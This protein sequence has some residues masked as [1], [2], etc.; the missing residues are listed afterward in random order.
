MSAA[1]QLRCASTTTRQAAIKA[2]MIANF[3]GAG[4]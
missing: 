4:M 2:E 1:S 3:V